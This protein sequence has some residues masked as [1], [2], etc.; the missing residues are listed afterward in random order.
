VIKPV[1]NA[2]LNGDDQKFAIG[3]LAI[4]TGWLTNMGRCS[5]ARQTGARR[6]AKGPNLTLV[7]L[8]GSTHNLLVS[9]GYRLRGRCEEQAWARNLHSR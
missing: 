2:S 8:I 3:G 4:E 1:W 7:N 9:E 5:L 6:D